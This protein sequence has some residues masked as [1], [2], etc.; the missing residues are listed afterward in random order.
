M[1]AHPVRFLLPYVPFAMAA[2]TYARRPPPF[3]FIVLC[4]PVDGKC[5]PDAHWRCMRLW[6]PMR[7]RLCIGPG[8]AFCFWCR[9]GMA[10][11]RAWGYLCNLGIAGCG[12]GMRAINGW[13]QR[14]VRMRLRDAR[15]WGCGGYGAMKR[16]A[17][18]ATG[19]RHAPELP[20]AGALNSESTLMGA[21][22]LSMSALVKA[23]NYHSLLG[24]YVY[25]PNFLNHPIFDNYVLIRPSLFLFENFGLT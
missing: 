21:R 15:A 9:C 1:L 25:P 10:P 17:S 8:R 7:P 12:I 4:A 23:S 5:A 19:Y 2:S 24:S 11:T 3:P 18:G 13:P 22:P 16:G 6:P 20:Q 14:D